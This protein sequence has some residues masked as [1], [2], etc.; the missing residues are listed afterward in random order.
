MYQK[1]FII[2]LVLISLL[3]VLGSSYSKENNEIQGNKNEVNKLMKEIKD[4]KKDIESL[5]YGFD[6]IQYK[7]ILFKIEN[8]NNQL[9]KNNEYLS[10]I[11]RYYFNYYG[12]FVCLQLGKLYYDVDEDIAYEYFDSS[13]DLL[14]V[15][16]E[17]RVNV[18]L[19]TLLSDAYAK[20][21]SLSGLSAFYWGLRSN[22]YIQ[23][24]YEVDTLNPKTLLIAGNHLMYIP[25]EFGGDKKRSKV[26]L[27]RALRFND[28]NVV[29]SLEIDWA[30]SCEVYSYLS[31]LEII[32]GDKKMAIR[33]LD[34]SY[35]KRKDNAF[36]S[37][38]IEKKINLM[39]NGLD[40]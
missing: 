29:D 6:S 28:K 39:D 34:S 3:F 23:S 26:F 22:S 2:I 24:A 4:F 14:L 40:Y 21:S 12:G 16:K 15:A 25:E 13:I 7:K 31:Q 35:S 36:N 38:V 32:K 18:E 19:E 5:Y 9:D 20:K 37:R 8:K 33:Y 11:G 27:E 1:I 30:D 17:V 10:E